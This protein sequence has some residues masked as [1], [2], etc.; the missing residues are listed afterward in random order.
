MAENIPTQAN[1][2][3]DL[4]VLFD[5]IK[6]FLKS[7]LVG[8]AKVIQ[9][10]WKHKWRLIIVGV[11]GVFFHL[12]FVKVNKKTF[13][14]EFLVKANFNS[15]EYLYNKVKYIDAKLK[16]ND[17]IF[18]ESVFGKDYKRVKE[19]SVEPV[20]D[21]YALVSKSEENKETF[22]LL[23]NEFGNFKFIEEKLNINEY[24]THR[25]KV[26]IKEESK[27]EVISSAFYNYIEENTFYNKLKANEL[28]NISK[29]LTENQKIRKQIDSL[30]DNRDYT[31]DFH[32]KENNSINFS[33]SQDFN[34][35]LQQ[36][37]SLLY[38]DLKLENELTEKNQVLKIIDAS[39]AVLTKEHNPSKLI[40]S[41]LLILA[42]CTFF[43]FKFIFY[44]VSRLL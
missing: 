28:K 37:R 4:G 16:S 8:I 41:L 15:V 23:L 2:E 20:I 11:L 34:S 22:E 7:V 40:F 26:L 5:K 44:K 39:F 36:K 9:F 31:F 33:T 30:I 13:E 42:Y 27:N 17:T 38:Q 12:L 32:S 3:I 35:L 10:F 24:P 6:F 29:Q 43:F 1:E 14:N 21:V 18:L 25:I 19:V